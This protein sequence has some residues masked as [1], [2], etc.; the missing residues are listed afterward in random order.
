MALDQN[1]V[2]V[3]NNGIP[4]G[5]PTGGINA[6]NASGF[7]PGELQNLYTQFV[8]S[9]VVDGEI[10]NEKNQ[11]RVGALY[12]RKHIMSLTQ[13]V[14][15]FSG[16]ADKIRTVAIG[17]GNEQVLLSSSIGA[18]EAFWDAPA[19]QEAMRELLTLLS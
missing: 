14:V 18:G 5:Y 4:A 2:D 11:L 7:K 12:S 16:M 15:G 19:V 3:Q 13:S 10:T 1:F 8:R 9:S 17:A 6:N